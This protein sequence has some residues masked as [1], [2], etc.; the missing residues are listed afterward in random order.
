MI[1]FLRKKNKKLQTK[2]KSMN[3]IIYDVVC[4]YLC[5]RGYLKK[6]IINMIKINPQV[7]TSY[8]IMLLLH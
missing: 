4:G 3:S 8:E 7:T 5:K 2:C 6:K 1:F